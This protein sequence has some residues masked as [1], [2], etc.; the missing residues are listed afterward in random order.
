MSSLE[1][2]LETFSQY[3][4]L[5]AKGSAFERLMVEY[6]RLDPT[7][8]K[9][10]EHVWLWQD[11]PGRDG[12]GDDG[13][14]IVAQHR[15]TGELTAVQCKFYAPGA[16]LS[17][18][19]IDSFFTES[20]KRPFTH[21]M[22][23][24]TT[25]NWS[26]TAQAAGEGQ[27][28]P[29][30]VI[31]PDHLADAGIDWSIAWEGAEPQFTVTPAPKH[32]PRPHQVEAIDAVFK[33][34]STHDRGQLIMACGTGKTFTSLKI[35]GRVAQDN[36]GGARVLFA[37]PSISLLAQTMR[38]WAAQT[39]MDMRSYPVCS[40]THVSREAEDFSAAYVPLPA[41]TDPEKLAEQ[42]RSGRR[43]KG[44]TVVFTTYQSLPVVAQ[45]QENAGV[46][47]FD[48]VIADEAHRT[49]GV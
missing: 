29:G 1:E 24:T 43:A 31:G 16:P 9:T 20:G 23:I 33:G 4:S 46:E 41:T 26:S 18:G 48:L 5:T 11:W 40:D 42:L 45:A 13:I 7:Y 6:L 32:E 47:P 36:D 39:R 3:P 38:E 25:A 34:F 30:S 35:A 28:I 2:V 14:D 49:T 27:Q 8:S 15:D 37:V 12:K 17:K 19:N 22:I 21:R 44:L 10:F